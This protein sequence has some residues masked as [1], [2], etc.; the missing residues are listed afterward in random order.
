M[1]N[2]LKELHT[3]AEQLTTIIEEN[4]DPLTVKEAQSWLVDI[5]GAIDTLGSLKYLQE[6][7]DK[8]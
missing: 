3:Y 2:E 4:D 5:D 1:V 7:L 8:L 6:F